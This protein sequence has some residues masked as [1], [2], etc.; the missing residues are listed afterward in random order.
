MDKMIS[1]MV[2]KVCE[3]CLAYR[4]FCIIIK[5]K[6]K[7]SKFTVS[8]LI[9]FVLVL[10][11][12][13]N[14]CRKEISQGQSHA[15]SQKTAFL[16]EV[17]N[18]F[19]KELK[20]KE[21]DQINLETVIRD[22]SLEFSSNGLQAKSKKYVMF[23]L[24]IA[25]ETEKSTVLEMPVT[26]DQRIAAIRFPKETRLTSAEKKLV[27]ANSFSRL[28]IYKNKRTG[29]IRHQMI[30][31]VPSYAYLKKHNFKVKGNHLG[32]LDKD[33][34]GYIEFTK[35]DGTLM[36]IVEYEEG[37][38]VRGFKNNDIG[39]VKE[40]RNV[41]TR[42]RTTMTIICH[43]WEIEIWGEVCVGAGGEDGTAYQ[44]CQPYLF[45]VQYG[46]SC[47]DDGLTGNPCVDFGTDCDN[48]E[49][50]PCIWYGDC[51]TATIP[52]LSSSAIANAVAVADNKPKINDIKKYKDCFTDGK[53]A[54]SYKMTLYVDQ[55]VAGQADVY[56]IV[57]PTGG[58][59]TNPYGVP[60]GV[61]FQSVS[62]NNFDVGHTFV[63]FEKNNADGS[64]V[65]Q[66]LGFYPGGNPLSSKG[67]IKD[68]SGH[69]ADV[70]F[71]INVTSQQ[72]EAALQKVESDFNNKDY[73]LTDALGTEYNCTDAAISW[74]NAAGQNFGNS[75]TLI[76]KN[77]PGS[78][79]QTL[80]NSPGA[81][82][83]PSSGGVG[84]GP[85]N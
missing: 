13:F 27:F 31:Y 10:G 74:M 24:A 63:T 57:M 34:S 21:G 14:S 48:E 52:T 77:T 33:F 23:H 79:G 7:K 28:A 3:I 50:D 32:N 4:Y 75:P 9:P 76:F 5:P 42:G 25:Y 68:D 71:T 39:K 26:F 62:G 30:N 83:N 55:P 38:K 51:G 73:K 56:K 69:H 58:V 43:Q 85:C 59:V 36:H 80:R 64:S 8:F 49:Y 6:K 47:H 54:T 18:Y 70:S 2:K 12:I 46:E 22:R 67:V 19:Y 41:E 1:Y 65:R 35:W 66:T 82:T 81:Y 16:K 40:G 37:R 60:T 84:K 78:F 61:V 45:G 29:K 11:L 17:K 53:Q 72:F 44:N 20:K 15:P